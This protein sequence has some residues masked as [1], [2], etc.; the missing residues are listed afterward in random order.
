MVGAVTRPHR[1]P[2]LSEREADALDPRPCL[3]GSA[4]GRPGAFRVA[5]FFYSPQRWP[6]A[7]VALDNNAGSS[8]N[9][10]VW[11]GYVASELINGIRV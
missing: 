10:R 2:D 7:A 8:L 6:R 1:A 11:A 9:P 4:P 5:G 3:A